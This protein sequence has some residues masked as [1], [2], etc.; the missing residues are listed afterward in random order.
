MFDLVFLIIV[1]LNRLNKDAKWHIDLF[2][3]KDICPEK[4]GVDV[5]VAIDTSKRFRSP[6][7]RIISPMFSLYSPYGF[8]Q[9]KTNNFSKLVGITNFKKIN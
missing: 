7:N 3:K 1:F 8:R 9:E 5:F 6:L 2:Q 4:F